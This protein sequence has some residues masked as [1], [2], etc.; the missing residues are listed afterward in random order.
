MSR[1]SDLVPGD[2]SDEKRFATMLLNA[3][4]AAL[5]DGDIDMSLRAMVEHAIGAT[6]AERCALVLHEDGGIAIRVALNRHGEDLGHRPVI[7]RSVVETVI[8]QEQTLVARVTEDGDLEEEDATVDN[9]R[10]VMCAP[11]G[12]TGRVLGALYVDFAEQ[13]PPPT[14][15]D[16]ALFHSIAG[17][18]GMAIE[19]HRLLRETLEAR[20]MRDQLMVANEIQSRLL[21]QSDVLLGG[22]RLASTME[23]SERVGGDYFDYFAIDLRRVGLGIGDASGHGIGPA[24]IMS[25]VR[26]HLRSLL[27]TRRSLGGLYG[28]MNRALCAD[29]SDGMFVSL[30]VA[31]FDPDKMTLEFQ[32]AGHAAPLLYDPEK[33]SFREIMA[34]APA[35]GILDEISAGPCPSVSVSPGEYLV[36][37]T[38]GVTERHSKQGHLFGEAQLQEV[39]REAVQGGATPRAVVDAIRTACDRHADGLPPRDDVSVVAACLGL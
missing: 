21:P 12:A 1:L 33:D 11:L 30:F 37:F 32:N 10:R 16:L 2:P 7:C 9:V 27:Q 17:V 15:T 25:N 39:V 24:L 36:C 8:R 4:L 26:A 13:G 28:L 38:D 3:A 14:Q 5:S 34:N 18:M 23:R 35:L 20:A 31:V 6:H 22:T 29:L 19:K